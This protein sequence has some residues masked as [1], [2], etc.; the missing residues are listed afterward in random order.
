MLASPSAFQNAWSIGE[1]SPHPP[2]SGMPLIVTPRSARGSSPSRRLSARLLE[3]AAPKP[4]VSSDAVY[5]DAVVGPRRRPEVTVA[6]RNAD[7]VADRGLD[8]AHGVVLPSLSEC[9]SEL[10]RRGIANSRCRPI[11][12]ATR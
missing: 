7:G 1:T 4:V 8:D 5:S 9:Q 10:H 6:V 3:T 11:S 12:A 2:Y